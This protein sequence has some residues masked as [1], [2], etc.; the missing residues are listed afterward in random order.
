MSEKSG[1]NASASSFR[2]TDYLSKWSEFVNSKPSKRPGPAYLLTGIGIVLGQ[3]ILL[4][5]AQT[6][7]EASTV[8]FKQF[9]IAAESLRC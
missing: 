5:A 2:F 4:S 7:Q 9:L 1:T 3:R 8:C 6:A